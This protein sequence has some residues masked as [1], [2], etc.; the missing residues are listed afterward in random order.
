MPQ[1]EE[2]ML[3]LTARTFL[4]RLLASLLLFDCFVAGL[5]AWTIRQNYELHH[6]QARI[7]TQNLSETLETQLV[8]QIRANDMA[9]YAV[10]DEWQR[11]RASGRVNARSLNEYIE[12]VRLR[13]PGIDAIRIADANGILQYG[14]GVKPEARTSVADRPHFIELRG[15]R[16]AGLVFSKPQLSRVNNKWVIVLARRINGAQGEF[17]GMVFAAVPL[18]HL[19]AAFAALDV[20]KHGVVAM[21]DAELAM[22]VR[23]PESP[24]S[25]LAVGSKTAAPELQALVSEGKTEGTYLT[26]QLADKVER[27]VSFRKVGDYPFYVVVGRAPQDYLADSRQDT[28]GMLVLVGIFFF[29]TLL[30]GWLVF[31]SWRRQQHLNV[32][33][34]ESETRLNE[35]F[36]NMHSGVAVYRAS[37]DGQ[38]FFFSGFN[39][40]AER[41]ENLR[42]EDLLGKDVAEIF[43]AIADFGLLDVFKRVWRSGQAE[44]FPMSFYHDGRITGWRDNF[45]YRLPSGEIVAIYDDVTARKQAEEALRLSE[46]QYRATFDHAAV[47]IAQV[48]P[49]GRFMQINEVFCDIIGYT[50][51]EVLAQGFTF[52]QITFPEDLASDLTNVQRLLTGEDDHYQMEKRYIR[53]DGQVVW[54]YLSVALVKNEAGAPL[55]FIS[56]V[57]DI[58]ARKAAEASL[59][60]SEQRFR[61]MFHKHSSIMLLIEPESGH[62]VDANAAAERFYGYTDAQLRGMS[63]NQINLLSAEEVKRERE[64]AL[65]EKRNYFNFPHRLAN[66]EVRTVEVYSSPVEDEGRL[67]LFSI[68][69]DITER[70]RTE[71]ALAKSELLLRNIFNTL[72]VGVWLADENGNIQMGNEA[73]LRIWA[74]ARFVGLDQ[75]GEYKGW[76]HDSGKPIEGSDWALARAI[77]Q[78]ETSLNELIDIQCFDGTRKTILNSAKPLLGEGGAL[79][80]AIVVI[81]DISDRIEFEKTLREK[82]EALQRSNADLERFAY[83]VSHDMRQ[84]LRAIS[85]H[86]QLLQRSLKDKLDEDERE[87]MNFALEG[88]KRMDSMIV[89]L[90]EYSRVGRKTQAKQWLNSREPLDEALGFLEPAAQQAGAEVT[91]AGEW[92]Q[93]YASRDELVRL[94]QNLVGNGLKY[95]EP[96]QAPRIE[97]LS[98]VGEAW[99]VSVRDNGIGIDPKQIE[100]LFQFFS[101]LQARTRFEG[102]GMGLALCRRIVEH[103]G[104]RIW[105]ESEGEGK[106]SLFM[107]EIPFAQDEIPKTVEQ[108]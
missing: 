16:D 10:L 26:T 39:R 61:N 108:Q 6:E 31:L 32:S 92:P 84:P 74:G 2:K 62:I 104:G 44:N 54:V 83:S 13:L 80:G 34:R 30:L 79:M 9:L 48:A 101:R 29:A 38:R 41:I 67:L 5:A 22:V 94:F 8:G 63:I 35:L 18:T 42:R 17:E 90:L 51:E 78:R 12:K 97:V 40:A 36:E 102:T 99:R 85:G 89:S 1:Y 11:Q 37:P 53:K 86:L 68:V 64:L 98:S 88:A 52:Q 95:H 91:V 21:R 59:Q 69:H 71:Q 60:A 43:P 3:G 107:F 103:H 47:G 27:R 93:V 65:G 50:R 7:S 100:R 46:E 20:G 24:V 57:I 14:S 81:Q 45:V 73:G 19:T 96:D 55:H 15:K 105:V 25:G 58:T 70:K 75:Y 77:S 72:P 56:S 23:Y 106:G 87:N 33:L 82:T 49:T 28:I 66:G 76:W 4:V